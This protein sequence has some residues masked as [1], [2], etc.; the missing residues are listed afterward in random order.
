METQ[1]ISTSSSAHLAAVIQH[2]QMKRNL[3]DEKN[4]RA[5]AGTITCRECGAQHKTLARHLATHGMTVE[6][7]RAKHGAES[8]TIAIGVKTG[9]KAGVGKN[10]PRPGDRDAAADEKLFAD[11]NG[12]ELVELDRLARDKLT[13]ISK[14]VQDA[15]AGRSRES[16][17]A[18]GLAY[19]FARR[20]LDN[21]SST[22][23]LPRWQEAD[24]QAGSNPFY[25]P[26][27]Y[28]RVCARTTESSS[29]T[30]IASSRHWECDGLE[31]CTRC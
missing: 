3:A 4:Q 14:A 1:G 21:P 22:A 2:P 28:L 11:A 29:G 24:T 9:R 12:L 15:L 26:L 23:P 18:Y 19:L 16:R 17:Q 10:P 30:L 8:P 20:C 31:S 5:P 7:Y 13:A 27:K 25:R 6:S